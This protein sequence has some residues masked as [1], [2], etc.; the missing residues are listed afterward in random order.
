M[1]WK[2]LSVYLG[3]PLDLQHGRIRKPP[4]LLPV[5]SEIN[6]DLAQVTVSGKLRVIDRVDASLKTALR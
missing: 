3:P 6:F 2:L 4:K 5:F 1:A